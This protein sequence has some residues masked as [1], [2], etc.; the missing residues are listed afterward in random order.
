MTTTCMVGGRRC[1]RRVVFL[2]DPG[3][4]RRGAARTSAP[5]PG[6]PSNRVG[7]R[8]WLGAGALAGAFVAFLWWLSVE[9]LRGAA[10]PQQLTIPNGT[11]AA[12][13]RGTEPPGLPRRIE[14]LTGQRLYVV[15]LDSAEHLIAGTLIRPGT[16]TVIEPAVLSGGEVSC[17]VHPSGVIAVALRGKPQALDSALRGSLFG[18][19][20]GLLAG[21]IAI[22]GLAV[23]PFRKGDGSGKH[24]SLWPSAGR[25]RPKSGATFGSL[26]EAGSG[27][28]RKP[29]SSWRTGRAAAPSGPV[30]AQPPPR[31]ASRHGQLA[32]RYRLRGRTVLCGQ[33]RVG[34]TA[35]RRFDHRGRPGR[36][37]EHLPI[38]PGAAGQP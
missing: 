5:N 11:N 36:D 4:R 25:L 24:P 14:L 31:L 23:R 29:G 8:A 19:P 35:Q 37:C 38:P 17:T 28:S 9:P 16:S 26:L 18:A 1:S 2:P 6:S 20:L 15:N 10:P 7:P 22:L 32:R 30:G 13:E 12:I 21:F 34:P 3:Q 27:W 33:R